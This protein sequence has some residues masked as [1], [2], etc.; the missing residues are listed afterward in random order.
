MSDFGNSSQQI[1]K[2]EFITIPLPANAANNKN[3]FFFPDDQYLRNKKLHTI[4][5]FA[6][7]VLIKS[8]NNVIAAT[9]PYIN[10][11]YL[12]LESYS[13]VQFVNKIP[14][15]KFQ[16]LA[17]NQIW[18]TFAAKFV[19]QRVNWPKSFVF[20]PDTTFFSPVATELVFQ[21]GFSEIDTKMQDQQLFQEFKKKK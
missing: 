5:V 21:I 13:G 20:Y 9:V 15:V 11:G 1:I 16:N 10:Q 4:E 12:L 8:Q 17:L 19:G 2:S 6:G 7:D 14:L 18:D 3:I